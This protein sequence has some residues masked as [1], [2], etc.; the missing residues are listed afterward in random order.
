M[1]ANIYGNGFL[2]EIRN[3]WKGGDDGVSREIRGII[4]S[5]YDIRD[6]SGEFGVQPCVEINLR[7]NMGIVQ[8]LQRY[9]QEVLKVFLYSAFS[10]SREKSCNRWRRIERRIPC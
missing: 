2:H 3:N 8:S 7:Y 10:P 6:E 4:K 1:I 9:L 5:G